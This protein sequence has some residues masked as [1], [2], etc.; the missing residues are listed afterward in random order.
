MVEAVE[1]VEAVVLAEQAELTEV[2]ERAERAEVAE[3]VPMPP[4][5]AEVWCASWRGREG[6]RAVAVLV[7]P[8]R[9]DQRWSSNPRGSSRVERVERVE[10]GRGAL[11]SAGGCWPW[12]GRGA[13]G[14]A[15]VGRPAPADRATLAVVL[16]ELASLH[17]QW[18]A[19]PPLRESFAPMMR[20][21]ICLFLDIAR[22][23][24]GS[25]H[26]VVRMTVIPCHDDK[27]AVG[28]IR[29]CIPLPPGARGTILI[30]CRFGAT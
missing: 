14:V 4:R 26:D 24:Q 23:A 17:A 3:V 8:S 19:G 22:T 11:A 2:V 5:A 9:A 29:C 21:P 10:L 1:V 13:R 12:C 15:A 20:M 6:G 27:L 30:A 25:A 16:A 28:G 7:E 18:T